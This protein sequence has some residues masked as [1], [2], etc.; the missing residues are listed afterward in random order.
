MN[1]LVILSIMELGVRLEDMIRDLGQESFQQAYAPVYE[2]LQS[3][4]TKPLY[5]G[6][7]NSLT[8]LS[9]VLSL[10]NCQGQIWIE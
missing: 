2:R 10:V 9:V 7:N 6:C 1:E 4:S 3:D 8:L 5:P